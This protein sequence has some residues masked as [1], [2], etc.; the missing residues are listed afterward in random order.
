MAR[1]LLELV[2]N[3]LLLLGLL[4]ESLEVLSQVFLFFRDLSLARVRLVVAQGQL[5]NLKLDRINLGYN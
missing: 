5:V 2:E 3:L 4:L 1:K